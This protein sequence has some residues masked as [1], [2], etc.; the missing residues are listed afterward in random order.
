MRRIT[1]LIVVAL[2]LLCSRALVSGQEIIFEDRF[3]GALKPGWVWQRENVACWRFVNNA[4]EILTEPLFSGEAR[5]ALMR[6]L[7]F[8]GR[9]TEGAAESYRIETECYFLE[10]PT[11]QFQQCGMY[12]IQGN[13]VL[14]K[15]V[16]A[17][18]GGEMYVF[19]GKKPVKGP[20]GQLR[21]TV[22]GRNIVAEFRPLNAKEFQH[23]YEGVINASPNDRISLQCWGGQNAGMNQP[24]AASWARFKYF[25]VERVAD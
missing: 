4:L 15:L 9:Q 24:G 7:N 8:W 10:K 11:T 16:F 6:P 20:G 21:I 25:R 13:R 22:T 1:T 5:N 23:V 3:E 2:T 14:F 18:D 17:N 12:W 19:P